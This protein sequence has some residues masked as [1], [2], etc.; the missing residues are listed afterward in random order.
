[1][2]WQL[3]LTRNSIRDNVTDN[4]GV[5]SIQRKEIILGLYLK[6]GTRISEDNRK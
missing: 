5:C 4:F 3:L 1:M 2:Q 6:Q